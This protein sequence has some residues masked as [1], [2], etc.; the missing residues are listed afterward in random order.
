MIIINHVECKSRTYTK[1]TNQLRCSIRVELLIIIVY[2]TDS[3]TFECIN[4]IVNNVHVMLIY[5]L[6]HKRARLQVTQCLTRFFLY[7]SIS[8]FRSSSLQFSREWTFYGPKQFT[9]SPDALFPRLQ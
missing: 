1:Q 4:V 8:L 9:K 6:T 2:A 5:T 3:T 7:I